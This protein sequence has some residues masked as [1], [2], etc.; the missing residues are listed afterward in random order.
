MLA[1][2][3]CLSESQRSDFASLSDKIF[4]GAILEGEFTPYTRPQ[5]SQVSLNV[6]KISDLDK[7]SNNIIA[8]SHSDNS[9]KIRF[10]SKEIPSQ[11]NFI[12]TWVTNNLD[13]NGM[14]NLRY[15]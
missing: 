10:K 12:S 6:Y 9:I 15:D 14:S 2:S 4:F 8:F 13:V 7:T 3:S 1:K 11:T 5:D